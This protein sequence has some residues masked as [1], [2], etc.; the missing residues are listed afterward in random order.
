ML[1]RDTA[2]SLNQTYRRA[3]LRGTLTAFVGGSLTLDDV[4][5]SVRTELLHGVSHAEIQHLL[6]SF[7]LHWDLARA[8]VC[9]TAM[10]ES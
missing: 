7:G 8:E 10:G 5:V 6:Q 4:D 2:F 3:Y 1:T 9:L